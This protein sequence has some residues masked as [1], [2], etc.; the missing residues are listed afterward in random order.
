[1]ETK[2]RGDA[3]ENLRRAFV[4]FT[5]AAGSLEKSY[6]Q[7]QAEVSRLHHELQRTNSELERSLEENARVRGYL[8]R[9]LENLP[10]GVLVMSADGKLQVIN[11][12]ARKLLGVP[13]DWRPAEES[14]LPE[15][16]QT[17]LAATP[18]NSFFSEQEWPIAGKA[19][20]RYIGILRANISQAGQEPSDTIWIVR[21]T[22]EEKRVAAE[23]ESA[24]RS[25]ALAE[26]ATVLAHEIRN[27]LGSMELFTGLLADAT[28]HMPE[29]RQWVTHLQAGLR[30]LSA[31]VNNVL[32]FHSQSEGQM[33]PTDLDRLVSETAGFL[34]PV[35]RQRGQQVQV[36]NTAGKVTAQADP[37]RL[38]QVF[39]NLALNAFRAMPPGGKLTV[40]LQRAPQFPEGLA[41]VDFQDEGRG[42]PEE[43]LERI[44]DAG[45]TT[46]PGSPGLG[47]SV[48]KKVIEQHGGEI[49]VRSKPRHGTTFSVF[50]PVLGAEA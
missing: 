7:L 14:P 24:R 27:P 11:P 38:K 48:C 34:A 41:Q 21:D 35:A 37:N 30:A 29:T 2:S 20:N 44:Y 42:V 4:T 17:M 22:T 6:T 18:K 33:L 25:H 12:E 28:A 3:Q 19:G 31:T 16:L 46:T 43:L 10:C 40:K 15:F 8:A 32:Q 5:Q 1:M 26:V 23:R 36:E 49:R 39:F 13:A 50:L 47:L 9:V 45:F